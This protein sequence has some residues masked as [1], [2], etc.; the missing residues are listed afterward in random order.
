GPYLDVGLDD[1][2]FLDDGVVADH[3]ALE[4]DRFAFYAGRGTHQRAAQLGP[5]ANVGVVPH[6]A[7]VNLRPLID[8]GIVTNR[9]WPVNDRTLFDFGIVSKIDG[10]VQLCFFVDLHAFFDPDIAANI[11][12]WNINIDFSRQ[13]VR[14]GSH[15]LRQI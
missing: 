5:F 13:G 14:V 4:H 12:G 7:A 10:A 15:V 11:P 2:T 8:D 6:N 1:G 3:R 9:A